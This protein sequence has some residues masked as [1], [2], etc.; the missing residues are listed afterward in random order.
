MLFTV[1]IN[2]IEFPCYF[3]PFVF[4]IITPLFIDPCQPNPCENNGLCSAALDGTHSCICR[5][6]FF[7]DNCQ[8]GI[9]TFV[10]VKI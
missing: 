5:T 2:K 4:C 10:R 7:G 6:G 3:F 9:Y 1:L 8:I